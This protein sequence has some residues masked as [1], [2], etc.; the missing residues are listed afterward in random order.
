MNSLLDITGGI[1]YIVYRVV[2]FPLIVLLYCLFGIV[3]TFRQIRT[4]ILSIQRFIIRFGKEWLPA[5]SKYGYAFKK[6]ISNSK[7]L[8]R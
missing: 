8:Y 5:F 6:I 1:L 4:G 3:T 7:A 2:V